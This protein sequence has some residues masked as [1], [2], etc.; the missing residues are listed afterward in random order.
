MVPEKKIQEEK[1]GLKIDFF[2]LNLLYSRK[3]KRLFVQFSIIMHPLAGLM[4][5]SIPS[6]KREL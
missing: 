5:E 6:K 1:C 2:F 4:L 3:K